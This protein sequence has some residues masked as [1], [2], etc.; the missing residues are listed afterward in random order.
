MLGL[1]RRAILL[2]VFIGYSCAL[3]AAEPA[4]DA[5]PNVIV[6]VVDDL[7]YDEFGAAGH[8][9]LETPNIDRFAA[10]GAMFAEGIHAVA[11]CSPNR[12]SILTGQYPT[13]HGII[14]NVARD[15]RSHRAP[16][17]DAFILGPV[18]MQINT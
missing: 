5:R 12:A 10:E 15:R 17:G 18:R 13:R 11:L 7:R 2:V 8:P 9:Y 1:A 14:D 3:Q 4:A 16:A 6:I